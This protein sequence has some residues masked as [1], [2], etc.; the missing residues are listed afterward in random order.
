MYK[1]ADVNDS[2]VITFETKPN[3]IPI[4]MDYLCEEYMWMNDAYKDGLT[5]TYRKVD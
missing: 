5:L 4:H 3:S 1:A 2:L